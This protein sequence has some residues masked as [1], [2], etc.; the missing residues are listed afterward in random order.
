MIIAFYCDIIDKNKPFMIQIFGTQRY[1]LKKKPWEMGPPASLG[2]YHLLT[3]IIFL[4]RLARRRVSPTR[5][6]TRIVGAHFHQSSICVSTGST[7]TPSK[8][9]AAHTAGA[10]ALRLRNLRRQVQI[11]QIPSSL[12]ADIRTLAYCAGKS[13]KKHTH[14]RLI[15]HFS[16]GSPP[17]CF[18]LMSPKGSPVSPHAPH[19]PMLPS[20]P[21]ILRANTHRVESD[22]YT[23]PSPPSVH[24]SPLSTVFHCF[25]SMNAFMNANPPLF[26][27]SGF[28]VPF[29]S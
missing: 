1:M 6:P 19:T 29:N 7:G 17:F 22:A 11:E 26:M 25:Q 9:T 15:A 28:R 16:L 2:I 5:F 10:A 13:H 12:C 23:H 24:S 14:T 27:I 4:R 21:H 3:D 18:P 20:P 8:R